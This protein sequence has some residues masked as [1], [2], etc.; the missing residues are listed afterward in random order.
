MATRPL[1]IPSITGNS[2]VLTEHVEFEW[3]PGMSISQKQKSIDALHQAVKK[4]LNIETVLEISSKSRESLGVA[5]SAFN[6]KFSTVKYQRDISVECAF[7]GSKVFENGGPFIDL[8]NVT[9]LEAK[10]DDRLQSSGRLT[11]F[12]FYNDAWDLEPQTAFYDWLYI[13]A[14]NKNDDAII[15]KVL[16]YSAFTDIEFNPKKSINCQ[17]YTVALFSSLYQRGL[18]QEAISSKDVFL[19][20]IKGAAINNARQ[21][22]TIQPRLF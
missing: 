22:E 3:F 16:T 6:L 21:N 20:I 1:F 11:G 13:N 15:K 9:S 19:E 7:Q 8:F 2:F 14:L 10:R 17:A 12:M 4:T 18:L 5:L